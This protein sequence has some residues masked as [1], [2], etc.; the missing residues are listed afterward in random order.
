MHPA[1]WVSKTGLSAMDKQLTVISNNLANVS[2]TAFKKDSAVFEDLLYH[3]V[4]QPG[5]LQSQNNQLPSGLQLG[6]G[7][8]VAATQKNFAQGDYNITDRSLDV[9]I[10][11][12]GFF[13]VLLPEGNIG[14]TRDGRFQLNADGDIVTA[15]GYLLE[16]QVNIPADAAS[17]NISD[18][19]VISITRQNE[20]DGEEVGQITLAGFINPEGLSSMGQNLFLE[21][22]ASGAP[23]VD[24][25]GESALGKVRSNMLEASNVN[26]VEELVNLITAQ[27]GYEMNSKVVAAADG[28]MSFVVQQL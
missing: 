11:G 23:V 16:P 8:R 4:R 1:L 21:T 27:R 20:V 28:M 25:P 17:I 19:G 3:N 14:Y 2:T 13:R 15:N 7:V 5:G 6:S 10:Q 18:D 24:V 22:T 26:S 9:A 12:N